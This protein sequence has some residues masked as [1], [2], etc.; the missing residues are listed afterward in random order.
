MTEKQKK[1]LEEAKQ[2]SEISE[3]PCTCGSVG[4]DYNGVSDYRLGWA[5]GIIEALE[6]T[7]E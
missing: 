6:T 2:L 5:V 4:C 1:L 3:K 7:D